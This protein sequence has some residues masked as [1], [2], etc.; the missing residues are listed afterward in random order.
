LD[1]EINRDKNSEDSL[2][3]KIFCNAS[4]PDRANKEKLWKKITEECNSDSLANMESIMKGFAPVEQ[5]DLVED[6]LTEKF[7]TILPKIGK[8]NEAFYVKY[9]I[10]Y[11]SPQHFS[12]DKIIQKMDKLINELKEDKDQSHV[13]TYLTESYDIIKRIK[14]ARENCEKYLKNKIK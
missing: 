1:R 5:Y 10:N 4:L 6:F 14:I 3:A 11:I 9:F 2:K 13:V 12:N 8:K 7:F